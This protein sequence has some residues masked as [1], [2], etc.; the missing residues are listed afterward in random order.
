[1]MSKS[2]LFFLTPFILWAHG[3]EVHTQKSE[4]PKLEP[5]KE[6]LLKSSYNEINASYIKSVKPIFEAKC[7]DCHSNTTNF[8]WYASL[9]GIKQL[10][11]HDI[12][13]AKSHL[14]FSDDFPFIS[15]DTPV[16]DIKALMKTAQE[17]SM[18]PLR[19]RLMHSKSQLTDSEVQ[20]IQKWS[21]ESLERL[22]TTE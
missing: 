21:K 7:F 1:M 10:I 13:E 9:P 6:E 8:P 3:T 4:V 2:L 20:T 22:Q 16:N 17:K 12:K 18:P 5:S 14:D 15:H 19:Y 11:E